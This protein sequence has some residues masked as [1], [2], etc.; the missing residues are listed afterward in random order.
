MNRLGFV[1]STV[2]DFTAV[3]ITVLA[4]V[5][6]AVLFAT[7][8]L[9]GV[10]TN[11]LSSQITDF[12][13]HQSLMAVLKTPLSTDIDVTLRK[14]DEK[15]GRTLS[16]NPQIWE[17]V[18]VAMLITNLAMPYEGDMGG[19]LDRAT[20]TY[21]LGPMIQDT[22]H[23][24]GRATISVDYPPYDEYADVHIDVGVDGGIRSTLK[25]T[26]R[27]IVVQEEHSASVL[28][29]LYDGKNA[30]VTLQRAP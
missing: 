15:L 13:A 6:A 14:T 25:S 11:M 24:P 23:I 7:T 22:V 1:T 9:S 16:L 5:F 10:E 18:N 12:E 20:Q 8:N 26:R 28:V 21:F 4:L 3:V 30:K 2:G 19:Y 27:T 29:P 17:G